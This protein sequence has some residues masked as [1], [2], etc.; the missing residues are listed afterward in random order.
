M[1]PMVNLQDL[2][3]DGEEGGVSPMVNLQDLKVDGEE[4]GVWCHQWLTYR[5][6]RWMERK[7]MFGVTNG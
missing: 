1:S 7:E 4:G 5:I 6:L 3:V 2:K